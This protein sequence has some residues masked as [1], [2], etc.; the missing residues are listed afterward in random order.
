MMMEFF[1]SFYFT[2]FYVLHL[3]IT[4][5]E[6]VK[7]LEEKGTKLHSAFLQHNGK[8]TSDLA[9]YVKSVEDACHSH[10]RRHF[11]EVCL[12]KLKLFHFNPFDVT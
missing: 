5:N 2:R 9:S 8:D 11:V 1:H 10:T 6:L 12:L 7:F 4:Y 3:Q